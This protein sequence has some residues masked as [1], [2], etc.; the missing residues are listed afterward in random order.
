[1]YSTYGSGPCQWPECPNQATCALATNEPTAG[2]EPQ[3][4]CDVHLGD[5]IA[6]LVAVAAEYGG[7]YRYAVTHFEGP[8]SEI[9]STG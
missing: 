5:A 9:G 4:V 7:V 3:Q 6:E 1:M 2:V 8:W